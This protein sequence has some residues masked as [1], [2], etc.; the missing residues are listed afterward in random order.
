MNTE[1]TTVVEEPSSSD[2]ETTTIKSERPTTNAP[3]T[4]DLTTAKKVTVNKTS[5]K[6]AI[7]KKNAK[8]VKLSIKKIKGAKGYIVQFSKKKTFSKKNIIFTK[9]VK[10]A[11]TIISNKKFKKTKRLFVRVKAYKMD[12]KKKVFAKNWSKVKR[13]K[14]KNK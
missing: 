8:K 6:S 13:V 3:I 7:K 10:K 11:N 4:V 9:T 1:T 2:I 12:R 5:V 14:I